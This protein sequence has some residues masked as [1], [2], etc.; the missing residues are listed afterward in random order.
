ML[1]AE[2]NEKLNAIELHLD[3]K[4]LDNLIEQLQSL[5]QYDSHAHFMTPAWGGKELGEIAHGAN[6]L[7]NH[8]IIYSHK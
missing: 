5:K 7:V 4:G 3:E 1:T 6:R 2:M 8:L